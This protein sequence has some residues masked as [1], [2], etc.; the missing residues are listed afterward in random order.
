[1]KKSILISIIVIGLIAVIVI[2]TLFFNQEQKQ[3]IAGN[4]FDDFYTLQKE[5]MCCENCLDY[6]N[7]DNSE[8]CLKIIKGNGGIKHCYLIMEEYPHSF[9]QCK[10]LMNK[11]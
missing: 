9:F 5:Q 8:D 1:M 7:Y 11:E 2:A 10:Q 4:N 3:D 6:G